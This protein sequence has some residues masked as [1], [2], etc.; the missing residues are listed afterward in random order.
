MKLWSV[1]MFASMVCFFVSCGGDETDVEKPTV[2]DVVVISNNGKASNGSD[3]MVI[4]YKTLYLDYVK[5]TIEDGHFVVSGYNEV[6]L[7]G[8][9]NIVSKISFRN[10]TYDV[11]AISNKAFFKCENLTSINIPNSV[12]S[13][14]REV[15][16]GCSSLTSITIP[17]SVTS[18]GNGAFYDC[19]GLTSVTIGNSVTSIGGGAFSGCSSLTSIKV[20]AG[21]TTYDSRDNCNA[22]IETESNTLVLGCK[23]T[24]IPNSV[25]S[26]DG[27]AF[28]GCSSLTSITIPNSVTSIGGSAFSGCTGLTSIT[29]PN[30]VT[31]IGRCA[32]S[33]CTGLTSVTIGNSVTSIG[34]RAFYLCS[35]LTSVTIG[36]SVT[37]I[38][39]EVFSGCSSLTSVTLNSN[40]IVSKTYS[41]YDNLKNIFGE[42]VTEYNLGDDVTSIGDCAFEGC[43]GLT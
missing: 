31:S 41:S 37:S 9:A 36:N 13:I 29:I 27:G 32:F 16:S 8:V 28:S 24:I 39:L 18:I 2:S 21:N 5:Y 14:G 4:D 1:L 42:Q 33:D 3:C 38:D 15:F 10:K 26:I 19:T 7:K 6:D 17:N 34:W 11:L 22:I 23:N 12:T 30:S 25:T 43:S 40:A 35:G 20:D